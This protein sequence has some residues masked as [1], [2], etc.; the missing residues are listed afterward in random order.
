[1][2]SKTISFSITAER[3]IITEG[4]MTN[5]TKMSILW[6]NAPVKYQGGL[7]LI[8][9]RAASLWSTYREVICSLNCPRLV[10]SS[11]VSCGW[12]AL[13]STLDAA[14]EAAEPASVCSTLPVSGN[15][16]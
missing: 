15:H 2:S 6:D 7:L 11:V 3:T 14:M 10:S 5:Q 9:A 12:V 1:M 4:S 16:L 13:D 8:S